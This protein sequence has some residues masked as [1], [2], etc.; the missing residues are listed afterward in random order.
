[1]PG[2]GALRL[3][4]PAFFPDDRVSAITRGIDGVGVG[5]SGVPAVEAEAD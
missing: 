4:R 2:A 3:S 5:G 1:M